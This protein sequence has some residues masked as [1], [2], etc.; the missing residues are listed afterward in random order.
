MK[1]IIELPGYLT[2]FS[3]R[4]DG[5]AG[6]RFTTQE[7]QPED[8]ASL[9][10]NN[11][12]FGTIYFRPNDVQDIDIKDEDAEENKKPSKRLRSVIFL[13]WKQSGSKGDSEAYYREQ[14]DKIIEHIK[15]KL[16]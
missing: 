10:T 8:F 11:G 5:S 14:M 16:D 3:S 12:Q 1:D 9:Q 2:G 7:L 15:T 6:L 13:L 4:S